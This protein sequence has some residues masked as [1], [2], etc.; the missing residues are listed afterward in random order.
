MH[1]VYDFVFSWNTQNRVVTYLIWESVKH[2]RS[3]NTK[4][5]YAKC[6]YDVWG[7]MWCRIL[8]ASLDVKHLH[9]VRHSP[10]TQLPRCNGV[11]LWYHIKSGKELL[12]LHSTVWRQGELKKYFFWQNNF[13]KLA[14][15][16]LVRKA[17]GWKCFP[18]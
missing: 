16:S 15:K 18:I 3:G 12:L 17:F 7:V 1:E 5:H 4:F 10:V 13:Q 11:M 6:F 8:H 14:L 9:K 2:Y